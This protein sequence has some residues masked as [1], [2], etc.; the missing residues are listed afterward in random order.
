[1]EYN[2]AEGTEKVIFLASNPFFRN[3]WKKLHVE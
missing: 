1:M 3:S 2:T